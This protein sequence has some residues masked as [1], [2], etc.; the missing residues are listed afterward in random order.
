[1]SYKLEKPYTEKQRAD[2]IVE[3]NHKRGLRIEEGANGELFALEPFEKLVEGEVVDNTEEYEAEQ[4]E[5]ERERINKLT[6][7]KRVFALMLQ[8]YGVTYNVLKQVI[9]SDER[10]QLEWD[11][12]VEL[13]RAN[14]LLDIMAGQEPFNL[15]PEDLDNMFKYAN[16][17]LAELPQRVAQE[18]EEE[19]IEDTTNTEDE[20]PDELEPEKTGTED[21]DKDSAGEREAVDD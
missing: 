4:A 5:K 11:L 14:P 2:F 15:T 7:T 21:T 18:E 6:M 20:L 3:Y 16:G 9:A 13:E 1:M 19:E 12:C 8:E 10:A 17:E